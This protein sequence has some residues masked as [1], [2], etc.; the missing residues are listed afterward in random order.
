MRAYF[1]SVNQ[2]AELIHITKKTPG[3]ALAQ[4]LPAHAAVSGSVLGLDR[5]RDYSFEPD[6]R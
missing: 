6:G 5:P 2:G 3:R 1:E 4:A